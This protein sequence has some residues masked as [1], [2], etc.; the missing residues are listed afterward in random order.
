MVIGTSGDPCAGPAD[1][2]G[3]RIPVLREGSGPGAIGTAVVGGPRVQ[4]GSS[5]VQP[6]SS[7]VEP[8]SPPARLAVSR[9]WQAAAV[10][11]DC[12]PCRLSG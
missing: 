1:G 12:W 4:P 7:G 6:G 5:G 9:L 2:G 3:I 8:S 10:R 11:G